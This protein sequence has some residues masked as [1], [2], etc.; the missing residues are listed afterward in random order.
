MGFDLTKEPWIRVADAQ[1]RITELSLP[2]V[3]INAH[4]YRALAGESPAQDAAIL[5]LLVAVAY[6][7]FY[8][9]DEEGQAA[10]LKDEDEALDRWEAIWSL[11][12]LPAE[13]IRAMSKRRSPSRASFLKKTKTY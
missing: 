6:T 8:R 12:H 13:P 11:Q 5:R 10:L 1:C 4:R 9:V 7:V 2:E 3:L